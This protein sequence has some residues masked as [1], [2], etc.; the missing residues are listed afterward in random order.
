M[1]AA[2]VW[3]WEVYFPGSV[4]LL[5]VWFWRGNVVRKQS[6]ESMQKRRD[7]HKPVHRSELPDDLGRPRFPF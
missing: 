7:E 3:A 4:L 1:I 5:A 2:V 6:L